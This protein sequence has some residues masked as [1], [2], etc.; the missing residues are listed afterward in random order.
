MNQS[1]FYLWNESY[2]RNAYKLTFVHENVM[3]IMKSYLLTYIIND[4]IEKHFTAWLKRRKTWL[5][6][7]MKTAWCEIKNR[8]KRKHDVANNDVTNKSHMH[9][10]RKINRKSKF[11]IWWIDVSQ[12]YD[13]ISDWR[14]KIMKTI[15]NLIQ[16]FFFWI[17]VAMLMKWKNDAINS[18]RKIVLFVCKYIQQYKLI[19]F[20]IQ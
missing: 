15:R 3:R 9:E 5:N 2:K 11:S 18:W 6:F 8:L 16:S 14:S 10:I 4:A 20:K 17:N 12:F 13:E 1:I 19:Y 7:T